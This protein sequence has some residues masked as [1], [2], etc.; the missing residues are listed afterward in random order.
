MKRLP[1]Q[2]PLAKPL[3]DEGLILLGHAG[4]TDGETILAG[5]ALGVTLFFRNR[6]E[7]PPPRQLYLSLLDKRGQ[8]VAG[9]EGWPLPA[10]PTETWPPDA[11][12]QVPASFFLPADLP[13]GEYKLIAGLLDPASGEKIPPA[14]LGVVQVR[15]R[16]GQFEAP[17]IQHPL[18]PPVLFGSHA[19]LMDY[20]LERQGQTLAVTLHWRARQP[21][22]PPHHIFVHLDAADG[23]TVAQ[24]DGPPQTADGPAPSGSWLPGEY[25]STRHAI[26]LP[27][28]QDINTGEYI[29][30]VG[31]YNP[32]GN[33]RLPASMDGEPHGDSAELP[34]E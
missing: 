22:L 10:Y 28:G 15:Q 8:G 11:L 21:L 24:D 30:R 14:E 19:E 5:T 25:I 34:V 4:A 1:I 9:W 6:S 33:I 29:L 23:T 31:L 20:D 16:I 12:V 2:F 26:A 27:A 32:D 3:E 7:S 18:T 13:T 17:A